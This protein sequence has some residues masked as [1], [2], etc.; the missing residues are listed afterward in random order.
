MIGAL[1]FSGFVMAAPSAGLQVACSTSCAMGEPT[2]QTASQDAIAA[3][4]QTWSKEPVDAP[5]DALDALLFFADDTAAALPSPMLTP[6][7]QAFLTRQLARNQATVEMRLIDDT[8]K[9]H[10]ILAPQQIALSEKQHLVFQS[11]LGHL[12]TAGQVRR[13]GLNHLWSRW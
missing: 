13:V 6:A 5:S 12:L 10:A 3:W 8:G 7:H 11:E 9:I 1:L 4:L 2:V